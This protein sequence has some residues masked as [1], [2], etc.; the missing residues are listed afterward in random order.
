MKLY[1]LLLS[2]LDILFRSPFAGY[3]LAAFS[4]LS[5]LMDFQYIAV[6]V[7]CDYISVPFLFVAARSVDADF[8][9]RRQVIGGV[10]Y[11]V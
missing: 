10:K 6:S 8:L 7:S 3:W 4:L 1:L 2:A 9:L 5:N 11:F